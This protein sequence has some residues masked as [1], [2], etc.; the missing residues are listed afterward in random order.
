MK[1]KLLLHACCAP[2]ASAVVERLIPEYDISILFVNPNI[3]PS[4][5]YDK[6]FNDIY[7]LKHYFNFSIIDHNYD[8]G[9]WTG[10]IA[11]YESE[12]EKG[13][14]CGLCFEFRLNETAK[15]AREHEIY[16]FATTLTLSSHKDHKLI[17]EIGKKI[18]GKYN[19]EY[20][21]S[22]FKKQEGFKKSAAL[23]KKIG[24]YKQNYCGCLY[25]KNAVKIS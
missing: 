24:L 16:C 21:S 3:Q 22:N 9:K 20:L 6:R 25:S 8:P 5:E 11:G 1:N 23:S 2:C 12:P 7:K 19:I 14:R 13:K 18:A 10:H 17:N 15:K 4:E